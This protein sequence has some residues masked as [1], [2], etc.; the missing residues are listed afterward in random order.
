MLVAWACAAGAEPIRVATWNL[1]N[2]HYVVGEPLRNGAVA[3]TQADYDTLKKYADLLDADIVALQEVNG[4]KAA[5]KV[6]DAD[7]YELYFS[8]RYAS[9]LAS[10]RS[11]DHIYTGFAVKRGVFDAVVKRDV[12]ELGVTTDAGS[13]GRP[14]RWGTEITV[15]RGDEALRLLDVH[16]KS[17]CNNGNLVA[18][19]SEACD[20]LAR[21][22]APLEAWVDEAAR[23]G[24]PFLIL[25]DFNRRFDLHGPNDHL[26]GEL[27]DGFPSGLDLHRFP[28][29][30]ES[31]CSFQQI[32]YAAA[33]RD[34]S[35][36]TPSDHCPLVLQLDLGG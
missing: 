27:D 22:R 34:V 25:G 20:T 9:D 16:L 6:F 23:E 28:D 12:P 19:N 31:I 33:D 13:A 29:G 21:Q 32:D 36:K 14:V 24:I 18:P 15:Q 17:G 11:S 7:T 3:R 35:R 2:L 26:W 4:P 30:Q 8:G 10:G 5:R 1:F